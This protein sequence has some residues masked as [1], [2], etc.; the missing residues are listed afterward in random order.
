[1][2][3]IIIAVKF[4]TF[5]I[6]DSLQKS[7]TEHRE[8]RYRLRGG[9]QLFWPRRP[10]RGELCQL[11]SPRGVGTRSSQRRFNIRSLPE[12]VLR[13]SHAHHARI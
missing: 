1:M 10:P 5:Q 6:S 3:K 12:D 13:R 11:R 9:Y 8:P 2:K 4:L 7:F